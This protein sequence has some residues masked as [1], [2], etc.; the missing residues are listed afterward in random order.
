MEWGKGKGKGWVGRKDE[1]EE[2]GET[3]G[4]ELGAYS[5]FLNK[6]L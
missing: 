1:G 6:N 4:R 3:S 2:T 5:L